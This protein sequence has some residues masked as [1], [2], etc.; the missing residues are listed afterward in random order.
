MAARCPSA[1]GLAYR[2]FV[3]Q[4]AVSVMLNQAVQS[5][6]GGSLEEAWQGVFALTN[7]ETRRLVIKVNCN[8]A[9]DAADGAG[10]II[11]AIPEPAIATIQGFVMA[12]GLSANCSIFDATTSSPA[13][14]IATWFREKV[15]AIFPDVIFGAFPDS[16]SGG[17]DAF[18]PRTYVTWDPAYLTPPPETRLTS[19]VLDADYLVNIPIVKRHSQANVTLGYKNHLGCITDP[20]NLHPYLYED[21]PEAS[22]LADIMGSPVVSGDPSVKS[23]AQ[24]TVLTVGDMLYGQPC[25][26]F[27]QNPMP[28]SIYRN[29]WPNCLFV[30]GD[31]V[32]ADSVM[33][34]VLDS[35][36]GGGGG[37]GSVM[38]WAR[39][40]LQFAEQ[41]GQGVHE[42]VALP[43]NGELFDPSLMTYSRIDYRYL[44]MW[45]S[46]AELTCTRIEN[47]AIL[48]EW[49]HYFPG[50]CE[51]WRATQ[52]D[53]SDASI[54]GASPTG[55]YVDANP[56][57]P[58]YY[59]IL[60][61]G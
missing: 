2:D 23:F 29:E 6:K 33:F 13:R 54:L 35:Q 57:E 12:G 51:V 61:K 18:D 3:D 43:A 37:C 39:R 60:F 22:V 17:N 45:A 30:S 32:A 15:A 49:E 34:D 46:G 26:N 20:G 36:P 42:H 38:G 5:L 14:H 4:E 59:Q 11:D 10:D 56:P 41:K 28:W 31:P 58:A 19:I 52:H 47:G 27:G 53:F 40:F 44:D 9:T 55:Q 50:L 7:P 1:A 48:L 21:V 24:K 25:S 8:N 16:S